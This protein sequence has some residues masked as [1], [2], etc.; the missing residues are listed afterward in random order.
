MFILT[1]DIVSMSTSTKN[2]PVDT[3]ELETNV[4]TENQKNE[5]LIKIRNHSKGSK[6]LFQNV[7]RQA[8]GRFSHFKYSQT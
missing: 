5:E 6:A 7:Y 3:M 1:Q 4:A 2:N 8:K